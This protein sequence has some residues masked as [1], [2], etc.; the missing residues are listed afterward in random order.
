MQN[1]NK[2]LI[3]LRQQIKNLKEDDLFDCAVSHLLV[4]VGANFAG[5]ERLFF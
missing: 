5:F 3:L 4:F 2:F 1:N